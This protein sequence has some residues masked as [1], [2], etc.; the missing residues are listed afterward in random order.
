MDP[1]RTEARSS[2]A[3]PRTAYPLFLAGMGSWF[4]A[5]GMQNVLFQWLVVEELGASAT[6][7]GTAQM[8]LLLPSLLF[9]LIGG[10]VADRV[11]RR[12][13]LIRLHLL[14]G[15]ACAG[16]GVLVA[17]GHLSYPLLIGYALVA[18][19]LQSFVIPTRDAQ[20][21]DVVRA[22]MSRAVAGLTMVQHGGQGLGALAAG[23]ASL[24]GAPP[25]LGL[26]SV[27]V[28][29][30][31][32][33]L[34]RLPR[35]ERGPHD[36]RPPLHLREVRAGLVE[37]LQSP[38]L[39]ALMLLNFSVGVVF[40]G[41][42]LVLLP[43]LVR[44]LYG[45]GADKMGMLAAALPVGSIAVNLGIVARGGVDRQGRALLLG[46]GFAGL[47]LGGM[48]L[49]LPFWGAVLS[50]LGWGMGAAFAIN[51][52]RTL[53]QEHASDVN[54]GRVLSVYALSILG[55]GPLGALLSGFLAGRVGT[56]TTLAIHSTAMTAVIAGTLLFTRVRRFR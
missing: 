41:T 38:V 43:L 50:T 20:L 14:T 15:V 26:Q 5:W 44:D 47:S 12:R 30:G 25:V 21:S 45:G 13:A 35:S 39:R 18:G 54:R 24:L 17:S 27:V 2:P 37:V 9:L 31:S 33:A 3:P 49:G 10:T 40:V 28:L 29:S 48:A 46:Q 34:Q 19:T 11:D 22:G 51:A 53:F 36:S 32:L 23:L 42:Y 56:L 1:A 4:G 8:A 6:R 55:T 16:L 7:V 52:S